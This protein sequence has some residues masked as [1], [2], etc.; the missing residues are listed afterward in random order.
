VV[1]AW[2]GAKKGLAEIGANALPRLKSGLKLQ[3]CNCKK[4]EKLPAAVQIADDQLQKYL[5][6]IDKTGK[7]E[8]A[9]DSANKAREVV[10]HWQRG[11]P[12][13]IL[14]AQRKV[15]LIK[16]ILQAGE[17][18]EDLQS[19]IIDLFS[20]TG[21]AEFEQI[22]HV[23][24]EDTVKKSLSEANRKTLEAVLASRRKKRA[25]GAQ[26]TAEE[27]HETFAPESVLAAQRQYKANAEIPDHDL[28]KDC[29]RIVRAVAP[30]LF[31]SEPDLVD[32]VSTELGKL[33]DKTLKMTQAAKVLA[34]LGVAAGPTPIKFANGNGLFEP[35]AMT[36]SAWDTII[37]QVGKVEGWHIFGLA[38]FNGFHSVVV[39]VDNRPDGPRVYWA[40][41]WAIDPGDDFLQEPGSVSGFRRYEKAGFDGFI[42]NMTKEWWNRVHAPDSKE[43]GQ[44]LK[45]PDK[46]DQACRWEATLKIWKF[47][48]GK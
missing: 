35:G 7:I 46:W 18:G 40:D 13:Y 47:H 39:F 8:T 42:N 2:T 38:P 22:I 27:A 6:T 28:R 4:K 14:T 43:C 33:K 12:L 5:D 16:Q 23:L 25:E 3:K 20:G 41:Q 15:L 11:D 26:P 9:D 45:D 44:K 19:G 31:E 1:S 29:I 48:H 17:S 32:S 10:R 30:K 21:G 34:D 36:Q 37:S 24:G